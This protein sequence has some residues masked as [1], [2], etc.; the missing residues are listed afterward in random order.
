MA[1][2]LHTS[3]APRTEMSIQ[4]V[5]R[6]LCSQLAK[7]KQDFRDLTEKFLIS[8][9]TAYSLANQLQKYK[10]GQYK[11]ILESVLG[12]KLQ[13]EEEE[14]AEKPAPAVRLGKHVSPIHDQLQELLQMRQKLQVGRDVSYML[15]QL[16]RDLL[17][18]SE[19]DSSQWENFREK[20]DQGGKLAE[21]LYHELQSENR[22]AAV[23][24]EELPLDAGTWWF[25]AVSSSGFQVS[26]VNS[27][28]FYRPEEEA[29][30]VKEV[31]EDSVEERYL[32]PSSLPDLPGSLGPGRSGGFLFDDYKLDLALD[33]ARCGLG[34]K[35]N[36]SR[37]VHD[38][39]F[40][41]L[42][43]ENREAAAGEE[44]L[45][46]DAGTWWFCAVSSSGF[47]V[48]LVNS[49]RFYR[50]EEEA[51]TVKEVLEDSVEERYLAPSS[52][53]DLPGS[54]GPGCSGGFLFD[55]YKLDLAL[56]EARCGL[57]NKRNSSRSMH[58]R[59]FVHLFAEN[60]EAAAGEE[61]LPLDAGTWWFCAVS[62]SGFQVS[63]VNSTRFYR[64]E[65]EAETVKEVLEDSVEERYLA[66][67][68]LPDLPGSLGPARSGGFL[69]DDYKLDL[70]LDEARCGLGNK[71]NS[72]R[73]VHDR[74]FVH[75]FAE[76]REAAAG[77]EELPLDAGFYRP[78]EEAE[79]V[80]EVLED[81]VEERYLAPL[82]LPDLPGSLGPGRSGGFLFDD[83]KLDLALDEARCGL[84]NKRNSSRSVHD[85][86]FVH[87][88][89]ENR[90][91][92]AGEE[93]L[94][95][96]AGFYRPE[97]E[98]ETVKEVL[99]DSVEER[100]LAPSSLPDLPGSLG[101]GRSG[102]FLFDDYKLDLALDEA[103]CGLGNKRNS[104]RSVHDRA[105]VHLFAE[106]REAAAGE[107]ELPLD[108]GFYRPEEEAET[109]K[110]VLE[111]SV[112]ERYLA[113]LS[114]PDL[115]GSLGPGRS[116]GFLFDDYKLDLALDE[117]R[118][119]L[120]NKRNSSRSVH[121]RAFVH[122]FAENREAA[123][124]EEELP[125]DAG[126]Y[127][128][129]E[130]AERVKEVLE[131]SV[132]E[133][134]LA[135]SSLPDLPGSLGPGRSGGF[136]F[137]DYKLDLALDE[138]RC[139]LGNKRNSSRSVHDR[140]FVHLFAENREAAAG[141]EE[142]PL[143]AGTWWF[144]AV[145]SSGFQVSLVNSTRFYRPEEEA[146]TV[147]EVLEDSVEERYLAPSSLPDLPGSLGP[148]RS[149]GFLFDDYKLDLA[150]DEA[151]CGLGNKRNSSRSVHDR[152][153]VHLFAENREAA[154]GEE[155]LPLDAG[156]WWFCAVSSS[157]FQV[158]LVNSTRFYR[159][160]EEAE[161]VK[162]VL[163]DSV[164]ERYLA[165]SS[166]P[167]LPGSLGPGRS[168][169]FLFDD[170]KL[171]LALDE[172]R[173][174]LGNKR[175]SSRSV[176]DRA[177]VHLFAENREAAAGEEELPLDAG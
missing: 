50:P 74:A 12:E 47:Q 2:S 11:D 168:G 135:P 68:S 72:S 114:L 127:R 41:H 57:G 87:L 79:T 124:G 31:L 167:D 53:P 106:N 28:R 137:D 25:C 166:L 131:D 48:S 64:P 60:R 81:S 172:A 95:L 165:P 62:S 133:R 98:A 177:F 86:A 130:E 71:R 6:K 155:E 69:F 65:E 144:C 157:G 154:A 88:F 149:G 36:S 139:G 105:F 158:S 122:L 15:H 111:D 54:L 70:A 146:E 29:E 142:L 20:L 61:E 67:S 80:K 33:E 162:E 5:N 85:R 147:K 19:P 18:N 55:D 152:A 39:A 176:H 102:G 156:T 14:L 153:F 59:A 63:L 77:E 44:E 84:G 129:E 82:S 35:R 116:G 56:D 138:A 75:L 123:A 99:E 128:P 150:L 9:A 163:E 141:E 91:A 171:D 143:D 117:A 103:R 90:E 175:N 145:S 7:S 1:V 32:A 169:G 120:G 27:T 151:R 40:V 107:E 8:Q 110:E 97:E 112:E 42:F 4:E 134:Y 78:E 17:T 26:L 140:A 34:N 30:T 164:E 126:F 108:A 43:A 136:L 23:G 3:C 159:P 45:P 22:E 83:Y 52:L 16:F 132:E 89:A 160:E 119:G 109:V 38:R 173:C 10:P 94:P 21:S 125:L 100:Y 121:D 174:G 115:P 101:P 148:G 104:S 24:E 170:Y 93:E 51:E 66:P 46:L 13:F 92:A 118:C 76:N 58:D 49:T 113:P 73:S 37:S 161:T 96:D